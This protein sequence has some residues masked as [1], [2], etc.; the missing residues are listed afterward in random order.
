MHGLHRMLPLT[1]VLVI[2]LENAHELRAEQLLALPQ[3]QS[4]ELRQG[5][6]RIGIHNLPAGAPGILQWLAEHG[7]LYQHVSSER[8]DLETVFLALTGRS[9]RDS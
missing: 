7:H 9:L 6:L 1:N 4:A 8:P 2:E 5:V 3:V